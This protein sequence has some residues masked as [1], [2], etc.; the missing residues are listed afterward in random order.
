M[1]TVVP[2]DKIRFIDV[3]ANQLN[4]GYPVHTVEISDARSVAQFITFFVKHRAPVVEAFLTASGLRECTH[5]DPK[6]YHRD[7]EKTTWVY[8]TFPGTQGWT[9]HFHLQLDR[10]PKLEDF[11]PFWDGLSPELQAEIASHYDVQEPGLVTKIIRS[12]W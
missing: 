2:K 6:V 3:H 9:H 4:A 5:H 11:A 10:A 8:D 1:R 7:N 12:L